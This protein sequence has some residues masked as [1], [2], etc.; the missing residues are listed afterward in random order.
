MKLRLRVL[1]SL[2]AVTSVFALASPASA[3]RLDGADHGGRPL[4]AALSGANEVPP[5]PGTQTGSAVITLNQGQS[6]VCYDITVSNIIGTVVAAHIH[7]GVAGVN[8]PV[9][10]PLPP[11][12]GCVSAD[13]GLIQ[14]IRQNPD[15]YYVNVHTTTYP[16][17]AVR[18]QLTK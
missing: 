18:G 16:G 7:F 2:I 13:Q 6:E 1:G 17:G 12:S 11:L 10:V 8:G 9:V 5:R 14:Q 3:A 15:A 4:T